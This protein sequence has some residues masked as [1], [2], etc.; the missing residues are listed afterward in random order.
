[1]SAVIHESVLKY[2]LRYPFLH[3][4]FAAVVVAAY[5]QAFVAVAAVQACFPDAEVVA[6]DEEFQVFVAAAAVVAVQVC[7]P[8]VEAFPVFADEL[9]LAFAV[10]ELEAAFEV[11]PVADAWVFPDVLGAAAVVAVSAAAAK[12]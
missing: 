7:S 8:D 11:V 2:H 5:V 12:D 4:F 10:V 3:Y 9:L 6:E 1:M